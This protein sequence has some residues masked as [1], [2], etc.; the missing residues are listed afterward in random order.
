MHLAR[1]TALV[2]GAAGTLALTRAD[3]FA[4]SAAAPAS[5]VPTTP[6]ELLVW[7]RRHPRLASLV[8]LDEHGSVLAAVQP[9]RPMPLA[10]TRK[11]LILLAAAEQVAQGR[12][13][14]EDAVPLGELDRWYLPGTDGGAHPAALEA[15]GRTWTLRT[16]LDA[17]IVQSDNAAADLVLDRVG[18]PVVVDRL[19]RRLALRDQDPIWPVR[20]EFLAWAHQPRAWLHATPEVRQRTARRLA[21]ASRGPIGVT[22]PS[23]AAQRRLTLASVRGSMAD[24]AR[25]QRMLQQRA[26]H[27]DAAALAVD[28]LSWPRRQD[29]GTAADFPVFA[30]KGGALPGLVTEA[31]AI[32]AAGRRTLYVAQAYRL[33][34]PAVEEELR[35][36]YLQQQL[37]VALAVGDLRL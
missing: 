22:L 16:A 32:R 5:A 6:A 28:V 11:V 3:A 33:L 29:A 2:S 7:I 10:S 21:A 30:T 13:A 27:D 12:L 9:R 34:P 17:M 23:V 36:T 24:F 25:L 19:V 8:V 15:Y 20:G 14:V 35:A 18:G 4:A 1:R 37:Y 26:P 31:T